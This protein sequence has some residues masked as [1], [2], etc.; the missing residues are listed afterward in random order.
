MSTLERRVKRLEAATGAGAGDRLPAAVLRDPAALDA[1]LVAHG[2]DPAAV[3]AA[4]AHT[5]AAW[6]ADQDRRADADAARLVALHATL[7]RPL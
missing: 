4:V 3:H 5:L 7:G 1:W 2:R 6:E